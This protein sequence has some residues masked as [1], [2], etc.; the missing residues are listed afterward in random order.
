MTLSS[1]MRSNVERPVELARSPRRLGLLDGVEPAAGQ[2]QRIAI[3]DRR[4]TPKMSDTAQV[5]V[6]ATVKESV[7]SY[8]ETG[9]LNLEVLDLCTG[10]AMSHLIWGVRRA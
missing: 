1:K 10:A 6:V 5:E 2:K 3:R 9:Q 8:R 7:A 4:D